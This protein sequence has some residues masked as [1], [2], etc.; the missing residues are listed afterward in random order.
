MNY[1]ALASWAIRYPPSPLTSF[2]FSL[3]TFE[4]PGFTELNQINQKQQ[5][6]KLKKNSSVW[7][8]GLKGSKT[9]KDDQTFR[10]QDLGK[11][12]DAPKTDDDEVDN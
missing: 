6:L 1:A 4:S 2:P 9:L 12:H 7:L 5:S 8:I 11:G 3:G 10:A